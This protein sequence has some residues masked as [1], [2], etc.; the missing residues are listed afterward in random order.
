[1]QMGRGRRG[2]ICLLLA[3][4]L[5][6]GHEDALDR[7]VGRVPDRKRPTAGRFQALLPV[8]SARRT[9]PWAWR[10]R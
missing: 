10:S 6:A 1:V 9:M 4:V 2:N 5:G 7:L 8:V 3:V